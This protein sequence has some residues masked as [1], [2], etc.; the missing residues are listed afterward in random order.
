MRLKIVSSQ[1]STHI[2]LNRAEGDLEFPFRDLAANVIRTVRGA[3][4]PED[5]VAQMS[6]CLEAAEAYRKL[7]GHYPKAK[8]YRRF[9]NLAEFAF[10]PTKWADDREKEAI[11]QLAMSGYPVR[12]EAEGMIH[13]G[14]MQV[15]ASRLLGQHTQEVLGDHELYMG[16]HLLKDSL[17]VQNVYWRRRMANEKPVP[18]VDADASAQ[19]AIRGER[20]SAKP[21]VPA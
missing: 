17:A 13:R 1:T 19:P 4:R 11:N 16:V 9:L 18:D 12:I 10:D 6:A 20:A 2:E 21:T 3:G 8:I 15:A 7:T 5:L 14:A